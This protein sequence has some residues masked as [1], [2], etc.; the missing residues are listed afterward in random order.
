MTRRRSRRS[1][2][3]PRVQPEQERRHAVRQ[4]DR[5]DAE[6]PGR[7]Q[8]EPHQCDVMERVAELADDDRRIRPPE[9]APP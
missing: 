9:I 5:E 8:R 6:R 3:S 1:A 2:I 4:A 7:D